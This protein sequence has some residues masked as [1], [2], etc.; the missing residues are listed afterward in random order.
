MK[1]NYEKLVTCCE[2]VLG[3]E[4]VQGMLSAHI[5]MPTIVE[6]A[7]LELFLDNGKRFFHHDEPMYIR[8]A[9]SDLR[10][11]GCFNYQN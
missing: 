6:R 3:Q 7:A 4:V 2:S 8:K 10:D 9:L 1:Y 5:F 11:K